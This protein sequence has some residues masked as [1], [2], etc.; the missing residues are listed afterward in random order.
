M[1]D[2]ETILS[3]TESAADEVRRMI[4]K[5]EGGKQLRGYVESGGCSGMQ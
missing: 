5:E 1:S 3:L 4:A 2:A